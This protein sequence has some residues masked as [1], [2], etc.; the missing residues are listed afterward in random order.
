MGAYQSMRAKKTEHI[1]WWYPHHTTLLIYNV[2]S[3]ETPST[4]IFSPHPDATST[5]AS[6]VLVLIHIPTSKYPPHENSTQGEDGIQIRLRENKTVRFS[7]I[8]QPT[9]FTELMLTETT[10][11]REKQEPALTWFLPAI[12]ELAI[13]LPLV[14]YRGEFISCLSTLVKPWN[15]LN[16]YKKVKI[17]NAKSHL[18]QLISSHHLCSF[19][20]APDFLYL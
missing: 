15:E 19:A 5:Q 13:S 12:S 9:Y 11:F 8:M 7:Q 20:R 1:G 3:N 17:R 6:W 10:E 4:V 2:Q 16:C 14:T 18:M